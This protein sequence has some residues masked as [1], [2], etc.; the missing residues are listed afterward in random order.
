MMNN[1]QKKSVDKISLSRCRY[2]FSQGDYLHVCKF[3]MFFVDTL[4]LS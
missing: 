3:K 2:H 4:M 1:K